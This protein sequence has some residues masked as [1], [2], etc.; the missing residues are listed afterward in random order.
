MPKSFANQYDLP[1]PWARSAL[2]VWHKYPNPFATHVVSMD[3]IEQSYDPDTD[4]LRVERV[5]GVQQGAPTWAL[6]VSLRRSRKRKKKWLST[7]FGA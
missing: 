3:V 2:A 6:K 1:Y 4:L 5:L 7:T